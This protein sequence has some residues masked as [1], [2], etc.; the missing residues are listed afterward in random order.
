[1]THD[2]EYEKNTENV[3]DKLSKSQVKPRPDKPL[4]PL[5]PLST[6]ENPKTT[7]K[8]SSATDSHSLSSPSYK[9]APHASLGALWVHRWNR[10]LTEVGK[11]ARLIVNDHFSVILLVLFAFAAMYYQRLLEQISAGIL[12]SHSLILRLFI[13]CLF[14]FLMRQ[15]KVIWLTKFA[16]K[17]FVFPLGKSWRPYWVKGLH[18]GIALPLLGLTG[19]YILM[20]PLLRRLSLIQATWEIYAWLSV[21]LSG[22]ILYHCHKW[23]EAVSAN[24]LQG[25]QMSLIH[26]VI[27]ASLIFINRPWNFMLAFIIVAVLA[28]HTIILWQQSHTMPLRFEHVIELEEARERGFYR[29]ISLFAQVPHLP[30]TVQRLAWLDGLIRALPG[31]GHRF[32]YQYKR[33]LWRNSTYRSI[34]LNVLVFVVIMLIFSPYAWMLVGWTGIAVILTLSQVVPLMKADRMNPFQQIYAQ[35]PDRV[36][37]LRLAIMPIL[38]LQVTIFALVSWNIWPILS[39]G[40]FIVTGLYVY[41]PW[42]YNKHGQASAVH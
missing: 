36:Q 27:L 2:N 39:G 34:W 19:V 10:F 37:G 3:T 6:Q 25:W 23:L 7:Y 1:M 17:S 21:L 38:C 35:V 20:L 18:R 4:K 11:Y 26:I 9:K 31:E 15:G 42:W 8:K 22:L 13:G 14:V 16:D 5:K 28:V 29:F 40:I 12:G 32:A 30:A 24:F 41:L 33:Q